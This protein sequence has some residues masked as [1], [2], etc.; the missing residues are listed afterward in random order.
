MSKACK[1]K[2]G[3]KYKG[4][5]RAPDRLPQVHHD[6]HTFFKPRVLLNPPTVVASAPIHSDKTSFSELS[7][8]CS[9]N[10]KLD[11]ETL[12]TCKNMRK[13]AYTETKEMLEE[14]QAE[15]GVPLGTLKTKTPCP[16]GVGL[17]NKLE[18][19]LM[20][21]QDNI[22]LATPAHRLST[23]SAN[24]CPWVTHLEQDPEMDFEDDCMAVNSMPKTVFG[25]GESSAQ[26]NVK[27]MVNRGIH[28]L[29]G[30]VQFFKYFVLQRG[31]EG[32]LIEPKIEVLLCEI[33]NQYM[34][35]VQGYSKGRSPNTRY[36]CDTASQ[37][38]SVPQGAPQSTSDKA[39][40]S[41]LAVVSGTVN[42]PIVLDHGSNLVLGTCTDH[43][44]DHGADTSSD[45]CSS[46]P[47]GAVV[48][49]TNKAGPSIQENLSAESSCLSHCK[50]C[51]E[52]ILVVFPNGT[53]HHIS[54]P[55][56]IHSECDLPWDYCLTKDKFY[57]QTKSCHKP[58]ISKG[59]A[60]KDCQALTSIP[61]YVSIMD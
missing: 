17:L 14:M 19:A 8:T 15:T 43:G 55:V 4:Q 32:G 1:S 9:N 53:N 23:F 7:K 36:G 21:I 44:L 18:A 54:Y 10:L 35:D 45:A 39:L 25:W 47:D 51:C 31:L 59:S 24:P 29:D 57:I 37:G 16:K 34:L 27:E 41:V 3:K 6:L 11:L 5:N 58:S 30:F 20:Q 52:G 2:Q 42:S 46:I 56:G 38:P 26:G 28:G 22:P 33:E 40:N 60:C 48:A 12:E 49:C 13:G 61:L 50:A